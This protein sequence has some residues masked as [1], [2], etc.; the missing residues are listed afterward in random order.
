MTTV[1]TLSDQV[2]VPSQAAPMPSQQQEYI[3]CDGVYLLMHVVTSLVLAHLR[4]VTNNFIGLAIASAS[5]FG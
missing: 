5:I 1:D 4:V 3:T 2:A